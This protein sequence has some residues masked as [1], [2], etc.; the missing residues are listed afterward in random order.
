MLSPVACATSLC[1]LVALLDTGGDVV[2]TSRTPSL[3]QRAS[4]AARRRATF[5]P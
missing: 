5:M 2:V 4:R 1:E 3:A